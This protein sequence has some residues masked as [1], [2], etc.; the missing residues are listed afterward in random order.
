MVGIGRSGSLCKWL[1][2]VK[3][4]AAKKR[5]SKLLHE[6]IG[7]WH[8]KESKRFR[9]EA[10]S[11][12]SAG[13]RRVDEFQLGRIRQICQIAYDHSLFYRERFQRIGLRSFENLTWHRFYDVPVLTKSELRENLLLLKSD[14]YS[15][16]SLRVANTGGTTTSPT[17]YFID[18]EAN[19]RRWAATNEWDKRIGYSPGQKSACLWGANQ[20]I[21]TNMSW[22]MKIVHKVIRRRLLLSASPLDDETMYRHYEALKRWRPS[23]LQAYPTPLAIFSEFMLKQKLRLRIPAISVTAEP[24]LDRQRELIVQAF[25]VEPFN[26]YG[27]REAGRI[28]TECEYHNGMHINGYGLH[29]SIDRAGNFPGRDDTGNLI[30]TDLWNKGMPIIRYEIG[31]IGAISHDPCEC[32]NGMPRIM[33]LEGR[34]ADVFINSAGQRIPGVSLTNRI[35]ADDSE[36]RELQFIQT[37]IGEFHVLVVPGANW[38]QATSPGAITKRLEEF[39]DESLRVTVELVKE[40]PREKSGKVRFCIG[41]NGQEHA[42]P[43]NKRLGNWNG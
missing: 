33:R 31:D 24:L 14:A 38:C 28:A 18:W 29:V 1:R 8:S 25:G 7:I 40:I 17:T 11:V 16:D 2:T 39:M 37:A 21:V 34:C 6:A 22:K 27:A 4:M 19:E 26:W 9:S 12:I 20:D 23:F 13:A 41:L 15:L 30:I 3:K 32:G 43:A 35:V 36:F 10:K 5:L 42:C